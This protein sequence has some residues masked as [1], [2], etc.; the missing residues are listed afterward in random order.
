MK[1]GFRIHASDNVA[2]LLTDVDNEEIEIV[3]APTGDPIYCCEPIRFGHKVAVFDIAVNSGVMKYGVV[4]GIATEAIQAG[5]WVHLHNCR[6]QL[7]ERSGTLDLH[8]GAAQ[9][10]RYE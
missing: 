8:T 3:G 4:I 9:D 1:K 6:S 10:V 7:D 2:T 5:Q